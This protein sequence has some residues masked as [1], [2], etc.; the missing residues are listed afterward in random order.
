MTFLVIP[1]HLI[2]M[3]VIILRPDIKGG[4]KSLQNLPEH[5][6]LLIALL[7]LS[8]LALDDSRR[9]YQALRAAGLMP[10][11]VHADEA[12]GLVLGA[13]R[14]KHPAADILY[15]QGLVDLAIHFLCH[16]GIINVQSICAVE[17]IKPFHE[18]FIRIILYF[19]YQ[20]S[21]A[22][23]TPLIRIIDN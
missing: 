6:M 7:P 23:C 17:R 15:L 21:D 19:V 5:L 1:A 9:G 13:H 8:D 16:V 11:I 12:R 20:R 22:V 2:G 18:P 3:N 4:C 10:R 14:D